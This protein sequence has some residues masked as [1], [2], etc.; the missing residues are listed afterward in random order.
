MSDCG[1]EWASQLWAPQRIDWDHFFLFVLN[2]QWL[3]CLVLLRMYYPVATP[4]TDE[5][6][7]PSGEYGEVSEAALNSAKGLE[8]VCGTRTSQV[9]EVL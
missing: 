9:R 1:R 6:A 2:M 4:P 7:Q 3:Y 8:R 5:P